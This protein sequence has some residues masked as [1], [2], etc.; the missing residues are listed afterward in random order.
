[1][2]EA[3]RIVELEIPPTALAFADADE[4]LRFW[5]AGGDGHATLRMGVLGSDELEAWG[6]ILADIARH[7]VDAY[8]DQNPIDPANAY[9]K[10]AEG[11]S[12]RLAAI[13]HSTTIPLAKSN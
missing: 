8:R 7:A 3:T 13:V 2:S 4:F 9:A 10:I 11:Y 6:M 5:I 12:G 1:M